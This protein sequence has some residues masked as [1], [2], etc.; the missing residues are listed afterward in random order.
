MLFTGNFTFNSNR[1]ET[2]IRKFVNW[3]KLKTDMLRN[4]F[5][6]CVQSQF[7]LRLALKFELNFD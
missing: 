2:R 1:D 5:Y 6:A 3:K 4:G 7:Y